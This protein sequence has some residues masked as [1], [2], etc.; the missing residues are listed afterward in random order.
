MVERQE[1][2]LYCD[3]HCEGHWL[4]EAHKHGINKDGGHVDLCDACYQQLGLLI[5]LGIINEPLMDCNVCGA[6]ITL[7]LDDYN[8]LSRDLRDAH[9]LQV[10]CR[11]CAD[12]LH[13]RSLHGFVNNDWAVAFDSEI[14][15]AKENKSRQK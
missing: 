6:R 5:R 1:T 14:K 2:H 15:C 12:E 11:R 13:L 9:E 3:N 7:T 4:V 10:L 8:R